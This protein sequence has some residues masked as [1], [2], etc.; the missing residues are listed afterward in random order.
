M[1]KPRMLFPLML[2][3]GIASCVTINIYFPAAAAEKAADKIIQDIQKSGAP[4]NEP[5]A[6]SR[7]YRVHLSFL[8]FLGIGAA[9]AAAD[10]NID[11]PAI[12][13]IKASMERRFRKLRTYLLKGWVGYTNNGLVAV[14]HKDKIPL[15]ERPAVESLVATENRDRLALYDAIA[16][17]NGHPEWRDDIQSTFAKRWIANAESGWWIQTG[18]GGWQQK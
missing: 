11:S 3:L 6:G 15:R 4:V 7:P 13:Q 16:R 10:I 1:K 17:A 18:D 8:D 2:F 9:Q 14:I 12:R 5:E